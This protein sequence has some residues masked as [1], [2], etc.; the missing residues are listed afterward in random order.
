MP[1][2]SRLLWLVATSVSRRQRGRFPR[3]SGW[4]QASAVGKA[5]P[6]GRQNTTHLVFAGDR[7]R[8]VLRD[9]PG[10]QQSAASTQLLASVC[11]LASHRRVGGSL[12]RR[13]NQVDRTP[14]GNPE[15]AALGSSLGAGGDSCPNGCGGDGT[16]GEPLVAARALRTR[17]GG[18]GPRICARFGW[19]NPQH[20]H[21]GATGSRH[22][23]ALLPG[24]RVQAVRG[25]H[26]LLKAALG[27]DGGGNHTSG[28]PAV[29]PDVRQDGGTSRSDISGGVSLSSPLQPGGPGEHRRSIHHGGGALLCL[30]GES[31]GQDHRLR[32]HR[33]SDGTRPVSIS[34]STSRTLDRARSL[35]VHSPAPTPL[36]AASWCPAWACWRW[37]TGQPP[38]QWGVLDHSPEGFHGSR[39]TSS[40]SSNR[41]GLT[42]SAR[43][44]AIVP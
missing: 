26:I 38:C 25:K 12:G 3:P 20:V 37:H 41:T 17:R 40:V 8:H 5:N 44:P 23:A 21:V 9:C 7:L 6:P 39:S 18:V 13:R 31:G 30:E 28:I 33:T 1:D 34:G 19:R 35:W 32:S 11:G 10:G 14:S 42:S 22:D 43:R 36:P 29:S 15:R 2:G 4:R 24:S 27:I 16:V